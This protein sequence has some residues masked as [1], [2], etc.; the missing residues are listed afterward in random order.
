MACLATQA[1]WLAREFDQARDGARRLGERD[2]SRCWPVVGVGSSRAGAAR[3][4]VTRE[5]ELA[6][7]RLRV[8]VLPGW[9]GRSPGSASR[10]TGRGGCGAIRLYRPAVEGGDSYVALHRPGIDGAFRYEEVFG[11]PWTEEAGIFAF[12]TARYRL[13]GAFGSP[14]LRS[15]SPMCSRTRRARTPVR[16]VP[17]RCWRSSLARSKLP[18]GEE[19]VPARSDGSPRSASS[20][21]ATDRSACARRTAAGAPLRLRPARDQFSGSVAELWPLVGRGDRAL[22]Q[23]RHRAVDRD[24]DSLDGPA[25]R[26]TAGAR[27]RRAAD[28]AGDPRRQPLTHTTWRSVVHDLDGS[29]ALPSPRRSACRPRASRRS[30]SASLRHSTPAVARRVV[31]DA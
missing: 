26:G 14:A 2:R 28:L 4:D 10:A 20:L 3:A 5:V 25:R 23:P 13:G 24:A 31:L 16:V 12:S 29:A 18:V 15:S 7:E 6:N 19:I 27:T 9:A 8:T 21:P 11:R 17:A 22:L 30:R 1:L